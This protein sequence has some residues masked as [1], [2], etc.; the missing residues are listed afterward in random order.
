MT[1]FESNNCMPNDTLITRLKNLKE[2][3]SIYEQRSKFELTE[4]EQKMDWQMRAYITKYNL[5]EEAL[6]KEIND[7]QNQLNQSVKQKS[8]IEENVKT[9]QQDFKRKEA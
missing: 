1:V 3:V 8:E 7:L 6:Q 9:L 4:R 5:K 2:Q